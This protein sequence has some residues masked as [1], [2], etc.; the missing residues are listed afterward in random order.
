MRRSSLSAAR[1]DGSAAYAAQAERLAAESRAAGTI[2]R[3]VEAY[4]AVEGIEARIVDLRGSAKSGTAPEPR[5]LDIARARVLVARRAI[6]AAIID[7]DE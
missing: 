1:S 3:L 5:V 6:G 4:K 2:D 7:L